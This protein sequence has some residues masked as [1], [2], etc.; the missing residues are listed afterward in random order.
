MVINYFII[1]V[2]MLSWL[3]LPAPASVVVSNLTPPIALY[4][5]DNSLTTAPIDFNDDGIVDFR[6]RADSG[7]VYSFVYIPS[8]VAIRADPPPNIG[9]GAGALPFNLSLGEQGLPFGYRWYEGGALPGTNFLEYGDKL[10]G[11]L[12]VFTSAI[13]GDVYRKN[14]AIGVEFR[15]GTNTHYG[16]VHYDCR[17]EVEQ[18]NGFWVGGG[19][20]RGWAYETEPGHPILTRPLAEP[21]LPTHTWIT[22]LGQGFFQLRWPSTAGGVYRVKG[23][24]VPQGPYEEIVGEVIASG[25][26]SEL[27]VTATPG[28]PAYFW[29]VVRI[30]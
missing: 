14:A 30:E 21:E 29:R 6:L 3:A 20:L 26:I 15:I 2:A 18:A 28:D 22:P 27:T 1:A 17:A 13:R 24:P 4:S 25:D 10:I 16:Y 9:G 8:R 19:L 12:G 23:S 7:G 5:G 11:V